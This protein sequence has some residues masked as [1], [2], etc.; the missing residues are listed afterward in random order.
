M[1]NWA[2]ITADVNHA[3][4]LNAD[5]LSTFLDS[6]KD[7][8]TQQVIKRLLTQSHHAND[9]MATSAPQHISDELRLNPGTV[10]GSW[11]VQSHLGRGGMGDVYR[12]ERADGL[13][14]QSAALKLMQGV[15]PARA[16]QFDSERQRLAL[17]N[18]PGI[19]RIIDGGTTDDGR[20][21]MVM[22]LVEGEPIDQHVTKH[23]LAI[24]KRLACFIAL[25]QAVEHAHSKLVLHRDI[26]A[27]NV[28][29]STDGSSKLIDF[30]IATAL[31][32]ASGQGAA[33]SLGVAAPEQLSGQAVSVQTDVFA[34][35]VLL[36]QL[37]TDELPTR[38][39]SGAMQAKD[40]PIIK[41]DLQAVVN[42][43]L[44][45][46][47]KQRY[48]SVASL[49]EDVQAYLNKRPVTA[50]RGGWRY[51]AG[52]FV[53]RYPLACGLAAL[54][55]VSLLGG[56]ATSLN[57]A[58]KAQQE[59]V[60][61]NN[62]LQEAETNLARA[63]YYLNRTDAYHATQSAYADA[64]QSM[65]G[66]NADVAKQT[67]MLKARWQQAH[68]LR[69]KDPD[70]AAH[71]SYAIGRQFLFRNDYVTAIEILKPWVT[72]NYGSDILLHSGRQFLAIAYLSTGKKQQALPLLRQA[73]QWLASSFD[74]QGPDHIAVTTQIATIT[75]HQDDIIAAEAL[76]LKGLAADNQDP[77]QMFFWNQLAKMRQ[78]RGDFAE[79]YQAMKEV[80][81]VIDSKPLMEVSGTDT[82]LLNLA[83]YELW[84][85][86][87][88]ARATQLAK[89]VIQLTQDKKGES[90]E[91]GVAYSI[92]AIS[93][94]LSGDPQPA[95]SQIDTAIEISRRY[96]GAASNTVL[97][98]QLTRAEIMADLADP[99]AQSA[100]R[101]TQQRIQ[102][103]DNDPDLVQRAK[104]AEL[105]I[106][107]QLAGLTEAQGLYTSLEPD[108][109]LIKRN[110]E[111]NYL[112]KRLQSAGL[113]TVTAN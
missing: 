10:I 36:H 104:L 109:A 35:G 16:A 82:G 27:Q 53:Q 19:A 4:T 5:E 23:G 96:S 108:K 40:S 73:E 28:L 30:G 49:R 110:I 78:M 83:S 12:A 34:L 11:Q 41:P 48:S 25:C 32:D 57:F 87:N 37:L 47:P 93:H 59:A 21:F 94:M 38:L 51:A 103:A 22:E 79:A 56:L 84:H 63:R 33:F 98:M 54:T 18:H 31:D 81:K 112:F 88:L 106:S 15:A 17:M 8:E 101:V 60:R 39:P 42:G 26:K 75:Q 111:L 91:L 46:E 70:N 65:F 50:R 67:R 76:L 13:Y 92:L 66:D 7:E 113:I 97:N 29:V 62:A 107:Y 24:P 1:L 3:H 85:T 89:R 9:F 68:Q 80:V 99:Q 58:N 74:A 100:F 20:P 64:L 61:A 52:K 90:R 2:K 95:L 44:A 71:L 72:E 55:V 86:Q 14:Q 45:L 43:C 77:V 69:E 6:V 102:Q 105:Y